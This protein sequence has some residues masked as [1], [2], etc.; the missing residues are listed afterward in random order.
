PGAELAA[1]P[2]HEPRPAPRRGGA[3]PGSPDPAAAHLPRGPEVDR[4]ARGPLDGSPKISIPPIRPM[5]PFRPPPSVA[6]GP[7]LHRVP[8]V[9]A[10]AVFS[11]L[12]VPAPWARAASADDAATR[13][14]VEGLRAAAPGA[15]VSIARSPAT[16]LARFMSVR[17]GLGVPAAG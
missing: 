9:V 6:G 1:L 12:L 4:R 11:C 2:R 8:R 14:A 10:G 13:Q 5:L 17:G 15:T 7:S 3:R 16:G